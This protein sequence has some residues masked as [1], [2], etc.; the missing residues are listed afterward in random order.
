MAV[1]ATVKPKLIRNRIE[2]LFSCPN[3]SV[4]II[5]D[6]TKVQAKE[7]MKTAKLA[8]LL[9][10]DDKKGAKMFRDVAMDETAVWVKIW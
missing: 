2:S 4:A 10:T 1:L 3:V 6:K 9:S 7:Q 8:W 5:E